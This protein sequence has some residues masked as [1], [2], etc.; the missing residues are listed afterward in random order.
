M[1]RVQGA[2]NACRM[3]L[4][5]AMQRQLFACVAVCLVT[6]RVAA[7]ATATQAHQPDVESDSGVELADVVRPWSARV[8]CRFACARGVHKCGCVHGTQCYGASIYSIVINLKSPYILNHAFQ[9]LS[10]S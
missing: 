7:A 6:A 3:R 5:A 9:F 1:L 2:K 8:I 4:T 10:V